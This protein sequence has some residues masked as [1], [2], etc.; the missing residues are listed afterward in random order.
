VLFA[1]LAFDRTIHSVPSEDPLAARRS[2]P[3]TTRS[4]PGA[5]A[6]HRDRAESDCDGS[7]AFDGA[8][9]I[10]ADDALLGRTRMVHITDYACSRTGLLRPATP[11][12]PSTQ[13]ALDGSALPSVTTGTTRVCARSPSRSDLVVVPRAARSVSNAGWAMRP[14]CV[15]AFQNGTS[16]CAIAWGRE[17]LAF[18]GE[19]FV[20]GPTASSSRAAAADFHIL[21]RPRS[22]R[23]LTFAHAS[24]SFTI[25]GPNCTQGGLTMSVQRAPTPSSGL[26]SDR[27]LLGHQCPD[28]HLPDAAGEARLAGAIDQVGSQRATG[29]E[30]RSAEGHL[31]DVMWATFSFDPRDRSPL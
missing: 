5:A 22:R 18:A 26:V 2:G 11:G 29:I 13:R 6:R 24:F 16:R 21:Y 31:A 28:S 17:C 1:E 9:V 14:R 19:S 7:R 10:D 23:G 3:L 20:C 15:A 4:P 27:R 30:R 12:H 25:T 8:S